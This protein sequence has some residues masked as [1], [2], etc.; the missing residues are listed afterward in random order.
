MTEIRKIELINQFRALL[1]EGCL[2]QTTDSVDLDLFCDV[3][4]P[5]EMARLTKQL[6]MLL[7]IWI[8]MQPALRRQLPDVVPFFEVLQF[9]LEQ[10]AAVIHQRFGDVS[11]IGGRL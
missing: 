1:D 10:L 11:P 2:W 4:A 6:S 8:A 7:G 9:E 3:D 5:I